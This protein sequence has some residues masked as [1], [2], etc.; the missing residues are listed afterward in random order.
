H[1]Q[2]ILDRIGDC[3]RAERRLQIA[4]AHLATGA[5]VP[6]DRLE[7]ADEPV[8]LPALEY[9]LQPTNSLVQVA[10]AYRSEP[11]PLR[12]RLPELRR[13]V[14]AARG[15]NP[16]QLSVRYSRVGQQGLLNSNPSFA[17]SGLLPEISARL[18]L[19]DNGELKAEKR[20]LLLKLDKLERE[21]EDLE[22]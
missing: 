18:P 10:L 1:E 7:V 17:G 2:L 6:A 15:S 13:Q 12:G 11:S 5:G 16:F 19:K 3:G 21:M 8:A 9:S 22:E 14:D 4:A 20:L